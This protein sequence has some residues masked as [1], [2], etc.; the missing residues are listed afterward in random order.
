LGTPPFEERHEIAAEGLL[1]QPLV[2]DGAEGDFAAGETSAHGLARAAQV[3]LLQFRF[4]QPMDLRDGPRCGRL[5]GSRLLVVGHRGSV[6]QR[7]N[8][9]DGHGELQEVHA[10][11]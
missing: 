1:E 8:Q 10:G 4:R 2:A 11:Y 3:E 6:R 5:G 7:G 9:D